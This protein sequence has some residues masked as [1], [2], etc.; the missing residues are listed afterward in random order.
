MAYKS[1]KSVRG[2]VS[3]EL[4]RYSRCAETRSRQAG[5][6]AAETRAYPIQMQRSC[7]ENR[8]EIRG[9]QRVT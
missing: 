5:S 9:F 3:Q 2:G 4:R 1:L 7:G 8:R 6:L